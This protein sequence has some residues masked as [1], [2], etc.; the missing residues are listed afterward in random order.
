M[1]NSHT[2]SITNSLETR[3]KLT[4]WLLITPAILI[5]LFVFVS[6]PNRDFG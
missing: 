6:I 5:L 1:K 3:E 2:T 4:G